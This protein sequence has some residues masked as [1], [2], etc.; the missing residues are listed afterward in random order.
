LWSTTQPSANRT[1]Q[2]GRGLLDRRLIFLLGKGGVGRSTLAAA[3]GLL[4]ARQG[5]RAIVVEVSGRGDI[6][7][8]F[9]TTAP[10]GVESELAP[11]LWTLDV[12]P[13]QALEEYLHDQLPLRMLAD[14]IGSSTTFGIVAAATPGLREMLT[15]G[16]I[17]E[18]AQIPRR[19]RNAEP[20]DVV[21]VDAPATG[22][23]LALLEAPRTFAS[24]AAVGPIARQGRRIAATLRDR[25]LTALVA[26]ATPERAA[27]DELLGLRATLGSL[28]AELVNG[29]AAAHFS[30]A[31]AQLLR[32]AQASADLAPQTRRALAAALAADA[33]SRAQRSQVERLAG[34]VELPLIAA[35]ELGVADLETLADHL[36]AL[37]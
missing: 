28:D 32:E 6:P 5:R 13:R 37:S 4:A 21:V 36:E 19:A 10:P 8:L 3:L 27:V 29:V 1:E 17:W 24:A 7:R 25:S 34:A 14:V 2:A 26:V 15:I 23:G 18:L 35:G 33:H 31:D 16:K 11:G 22:H 20:Y 12:D 30:A 9:G